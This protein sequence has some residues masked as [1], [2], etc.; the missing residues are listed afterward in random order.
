MR[1][2]NALF[3][4]GFI[5]IFLIGN[6]LNAQENWQFS[7]GNKNKKPDFVN[8]EKN[9]QYDVQKGYGFDFANVEKVKIQ[10]NKN[11]YCNAE[12]PFYFSAKVPEGTYEVIITFGA[13]N[14]ASETTVKA[15]SKRLMLTGIKTAKKQEV[16]KSI[17]VNVKNIK[18]DATNSIR[19]KERSIPYLNWDDK[20][21]LEFSG[22][23]PAV[24]SIEIKPKENFTTLFL[25]GDST[26]TDQ[27][28]SPY[29]SWGQMITN[30]FN[31]NLA[32]AN[33]AESGAT[34]I[35]FKNT[36]RLDKILSLL[37]PGDFVGI[38]FGHNDQKRKGEGIGPWTSYTD[39]LHEF[40]AKIKAKGG[41]PFLLTPTQRRS[42]DK[43]GNIKDTHKD[44][45][46]AMRKVA[47]DLNVPLIDLHA[48]TRTLYES[49]GTEL[50]TKAFVQ[51][52]ANTFP[53]QTKKL[54]DNTHFNEF[55][56][57]EIA[58]CVRKGILDQQLSLQKFL[59]NT[60]NK[61]Q[62]NTPNSPTNWSI[63]MSPRF[64]YVKPLGN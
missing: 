41:N 20:L 53:G 7:F 27:D 52:P 46:A 14:K 57:H 32:V 21:T 60:T 37:K 9:I 49:W 29:A 4:V 17:T 23:Y 58:L 38:E 47:K 34:L 45:P 36:K 63:Q 26:V 40:I 44:Y 5:L 64:N 61:Y 3:S 19:L 62:P 28:Y 1:F 18:I 16:K 30:Y 54:K 43:L 8:I 15:E 25:A 51:Y 10:S 13:N 56:A 35:S 2:K 33:Y 31:N 39:L 22:K 48:M 6:L 50:S 11:G 59:N 24:K 55:G 12:V 42:F